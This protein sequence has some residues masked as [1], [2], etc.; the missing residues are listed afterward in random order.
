MMTSKKFE[1]G[2]EYVLC[3]TC[4]SELVG[5]VPTG[6]VAAFV[7]GK[8]ALC[9]RELGELG[10]GGLYVVRTTISE[11]RA[12]V[13]RLAAQDNERIKRDELW[14]AGIDPDSR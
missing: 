5:L 13:D 7:G 10:G 8:C 2:V 12:E 1:T 14:A 3:G 11:A 4:D 9:E 6:Q